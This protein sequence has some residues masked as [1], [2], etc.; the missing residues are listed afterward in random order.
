MSKHTPGPWDVD[1]NSSDGQWYIRPHRQGFMLAV[2]D[3][4]AIQGNDW[5]HEANARLIAAAPELRAEVAGLT[6][7]AHQA[8][9]AAEDI[10][11]MAD[12]FISTKDAESLRNY[13][14]NISS[15]LRAAQPKPEA[16]GGGK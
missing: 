13:A 5:T 2:I 15:L 6:Q 4:S 9:L 14:R 11:E 1:L 16:F 7:A 10:V 8:I 3:P 12:D